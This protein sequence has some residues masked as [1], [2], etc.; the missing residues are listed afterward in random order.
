[1]QPKLNR[2][3][4]ALAREGLEV[5]Y[6]GHLYTVRLQGDANAP[7]AEVLLPP[8]LPVEGKAFRQLAHL[9]SLKHPRGGAVLRVRATPDFHP[10]D[11]GVAIG[12]VLHT[13]GLVVPAAVGTDINC[14]MR[15]HVAD[16]SVDTFLSRRD[17]F[18]ARMK[19]HYFFGTRDVAMTSRAAEALF[20]DGL[21]GWLLETLEAPHGCAAR[22]D[23]RQLER[24]TA[25]VHLGGALEGD[26]A[27][28]PPGLLK[29][30]VVR[31][32][33]LAT[34]GGGNHFVEVQRVEAV[35]DRARAWAW[36]VRE[37]QL[38]FMIH[39][40][41]RDVGKHVGV[42]WQDR[43]RAA[44][45]AGE[46]FPESG[47]L[48]LEDPALVAEYLRAEA[49][50]AHYAFLNRLLLAELLRQTLREL[51]GD[52]EAPLVYD[53]PHN[54]TLPYEGGWLARK[55]ACPAE[56]EQ[57]V[58]IPGSMGTSSFLMVGRGDA[59]AL[60][61]ASHGAGRSRSRFDMA[62]GGAD[63]REEALGLTGVDCISLR[64][65]RRIEEAPAAYKPIGPVVA[66]QVEAGIVGEVA[67]LAPLLTFKA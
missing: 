63:R 8:E 26:P 41:S 6:D 23:L 33:G 57:P 44:W 61:T 14:G 55:G 30:G 58:I 3:L 42:A 66:S 4:R 13:R 37:G 22:A 48:P 5:T 34:I 25:R 65:E 67:R 50:A 54:L 53:V 12:S 64:A 43:A 51:F 21:P 45:P 10:G 39:S 36:G 24:E 46:P 40:G 32:A 62:R 16:L 60:Q 20:R 19:G 11:T 27:W 59:A 35:A 1:M 9:A 2:L 49:T 38:A 18:V 29:E 7:P 17:D 31:D 47:I 15:L 56:D 28:A 52:V